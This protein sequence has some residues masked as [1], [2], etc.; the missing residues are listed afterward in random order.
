M[1]YFPLVFANSRVVIGMT[2]TRSDLV[3]IIIKMIIVLNF[4]TFIPLSP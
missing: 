1:F 2:G 3:E 4:C